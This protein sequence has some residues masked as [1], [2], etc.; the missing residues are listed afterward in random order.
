MYHT[1]TGAGEG[2]KSVL[3]TGKSS[4]QNQIFLALVKGYSVHLPGCPKQ[5]Q[6][7]IS[8]F[9]F[10]ESSWITDWHP[11]SLAHRTMS[12][13]INPSVLVHFQRGRKERKTV[14]PHPL[15]EHCAAILGRPA[16]RRQPVPLYWHRLSGVQRHTAHT[17]CQYTE[18]DAQFV[19]V[20]PNIWKH[21]VNSVATS[22]LLETFQDTNKMWSAETKAINCGELSCVSRSQQAGPSVPCIWGTPRRMAAANLGGEKCT[23][24]EVRGLFLRKSTI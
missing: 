22:W 12:T 9:Q 8:L 2:H 13:S 21:L 15:T 1:K 10:P 5:K 3:G 11:L 4:G 7:P 14:R 23:V 20:S 24:E 6:L 17:A 19:P 18:L 16:H